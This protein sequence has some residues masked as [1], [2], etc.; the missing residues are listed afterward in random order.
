MA[1]RPEKRISRVLGD[2]CG[3]RAA[4]RRAVLGRARRGVAVAL[5]VC[6]LA[7]VLTASPAS[8]ETEQVN[9]YS[10]RQEALIK[11]LLDAFSQKTGITVNLVSAKADALL[12]RLRRE[13]LNSPADLLLTAD[14]GRLYRAQAAGVLQPVR[15]SYLEANIPA[16]FR[17]P[18]GH[19]FGL[20]VRARP[21]VYLFVSVSI[22]SAT[23]NC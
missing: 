23:A 2:P 10:F 13:G 16:R 21:I 11:P 5:G 18:E 19:W 22:A 20:S 8:A 4:M 12:E 9:V 1:S 17:D 3:R 14:A 15:S 6:L 7:G